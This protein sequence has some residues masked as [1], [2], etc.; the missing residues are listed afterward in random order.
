[1]TVKLEQPW[2]RR[3]T[4]HSALNPV[5]VP[6]KSDVNR[7]TAEFVDVVKVVALLQ[8]WDGTT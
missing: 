8:Q 3:N 1:M 7:S 6:E 4:L 5:E 2:S